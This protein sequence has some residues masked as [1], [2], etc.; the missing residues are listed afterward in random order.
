M[1]PSEYRDTDVENKY[2]DFKGGKGRMG[3]IGR[4]GL[5]YVYTIATIYKIEN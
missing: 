5:T 2:M 4:L 1:R 3:E